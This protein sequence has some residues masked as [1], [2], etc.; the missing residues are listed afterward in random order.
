[1]SIN[2]SHNRYIKGG[3]L[4]KC[5]KC[6][7]RY[8]ARPAISRV[9]NKTKICPMCGQKEAL[10]EFKGYLKINHDKSPRKE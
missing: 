3:T 8:N 5:P 7:G 9:D 2:H 10:E 6:G 4:S 1:M